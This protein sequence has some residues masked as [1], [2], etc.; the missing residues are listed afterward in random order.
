MAV[1]ER[2][3]QIFERTPIN[4]YLGFRMEVCE[5][6][7]A[8]LSMEPREEFLQEGGTV[9]GGIVSALADSA[10][11]YSFVPSLTE[12]ERLTGVEY[13]VNFLEP[14]LADGG[15]LLARASVLRRGRRLGTTEVS[16]SQL[17][18]SIAR[19]LFTFMFL[20]PLNAREGGGE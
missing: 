18:R 5:P 10:A 20:E 11:A 6:G 3:Q 8:V 1:P 13:K 7:E 12:G 4:Q 17:D 9:H 2:V 19:A 16:V 15:L 14:A